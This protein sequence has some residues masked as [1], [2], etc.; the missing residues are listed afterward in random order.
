VNRLSIERRGQVV[1]CLI[2]GMS[3]RATVRIT[4]VAKN[5]VVK[6]L[7]DL[8]EACAEYQDAVLTNLPCGRIECEEIWSFCYSKQKNVPE[9]HRGTFGYGDVWTWTAIDAD[10]SSSRRGWSGNGP[11]RT[12]T[13]PCRT[14]SPGCATGCS[15]PAT[16]TGPT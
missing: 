9:E 13:C 5:T 10:T 16:V 2:E 14:S 8:G 3:I 11:P 7:A 1:S 6:L 12:L 15:S 4:G